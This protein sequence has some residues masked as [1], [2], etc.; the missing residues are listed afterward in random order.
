MFKNENR[1]IIMG[2]KY[3]F[4]IILIC[5]SRRITNVRRIFK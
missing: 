5:I 1:C 4:Q 2:I 3:L